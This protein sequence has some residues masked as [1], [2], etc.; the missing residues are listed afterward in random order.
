MC[1]YLYVGGK[2]T[3]KKN[4]MR[5]IIITMLISFSNLM[6]SQDSLG[7][8]TLK[9]VTFEMLLDSTNMT[10]EVPI[11]YIEVQ[12]IQNSQMNY[13]KAYKHPTERFEV[14]YAIRRHDFGRY[15]QMFEMTA[16]NISDGRLHEYSDFGTEAVK[17]EFNAD[18]GCVVTL[19]VG[20]EFGQDYKYCMLVYIVKK[21]VGGGNIFYLADDINIM[22][23]LVMPIYYSLKFGEEK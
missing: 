15:H 3:N 14:R 13:E 8:D 2:I 17:K 4:I 10:F 12:P 20:E 21:G 1:V 7:V 22:P 19:L 9:Q 23:D 11:D 6:F 5:L 18:A 16:L